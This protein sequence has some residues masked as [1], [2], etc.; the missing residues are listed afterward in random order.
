MPL[1][2]SDQAD[3]FIASYLGQ[4]LDSSIVRRMEFIGKTR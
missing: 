2:L 4:Y 3:D 1:P